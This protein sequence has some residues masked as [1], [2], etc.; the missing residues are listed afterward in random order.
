MNTGLSKFTGKKGRKMEGSRGKR[1]NSSK[2]RA[3]EH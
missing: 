2:E 3:E 1:R